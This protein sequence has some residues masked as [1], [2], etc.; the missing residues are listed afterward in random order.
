MS[1]TAESVNGSGPLMRMPTMSGGWPLLGHLPGFLKD[2]VSLLTR[3]WSA[4]GDLFRFKIGFSNFALF[5]GL[6]AHDFYF[7]AGQDEL[8]AKACYQFTVPIFG[9]GVAY[10]VAPEL[11]AEQ[12]GFLF[13]ALRDN[14]MRRYAKI[15]YHEVCMYADSL[16]KE[17]Q[18]DL[19]A[20]LNELTVRN[21]SH[22]LICKEVR[23]EASSEFAAAYH[24][25]QNGINTL[26]FFFPNLP[27]AAHRSRDRARQKIHQ[28]FSKIMEKRRREGSDEQ[29]FMQTLMEARYKDGRALTDDEISGILV[30]VLFA[31][32]HTSA[33]LG[34]WTMLE[35]MRDTAYLARVREENEKL[36]SDTGFMELT[37]LKQQ[38]IL[39]YAIREGERL[40]PPLI[41]LIRKVLK[42]LVYNGYEIPVGTLAMV[43]PAVS[44]R[45]E[46]IFSDPERFN[47]DRY[48]PP[49]REDKQ[50]HY[51]LIGFG[52]GKHRCMGKAF[53]I[54]Q[55]K[56][57]LGVLFDRFD[58]SIN[59]CF[60]LPNYRSWVTGPT[61]PCLVNYKRR[62]EPSILKTEVA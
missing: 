15:M 35:L 7:R 2:P 54:L 11:M 53:A 51:T 28:I 18:L 20:A 3:G 38:S 57:V 33:V 12:L 58:F 59:S 22:S 16:G 44:H 55:L 25:L 56:I 34:T 30:T 23:H 39:E 47:P 32:Q 1:Q 13:P 36:Y 19:P 5:T 10:D 60:P 21:A 41:L 46:H 62:L 27:T 8:S 61:E 37:T 50:H 4:E 40:H 17:G 48:A 24:E 31:G 26:G 6:E 42:P 29:D 14:A 52:G 45:L 43:S 9:K 49:A